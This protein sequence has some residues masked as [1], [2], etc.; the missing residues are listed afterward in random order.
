M[1][2][3]LRPQIEAEIEQRNIE[4]LE[5]ETSPLRLVYTFAYDLALGVYIDTLHALGRF[6]L[7]YWL[8]VE[9]TFDIDGDVPRLGFDLTALADV[10]RAPIPCGA[11]MSASIAEMLRALANARPAFME[12]GRD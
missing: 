8:C 3:V 4:P 1:F 6:G 10:I 2:A 11:T 9:Y 5:V 7:R 12:R